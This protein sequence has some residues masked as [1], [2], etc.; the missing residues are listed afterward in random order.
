M[1]FLPRL[2]QTGIG[3]DRLCDHTITVL[4]VGRVTFRSE[5]SRKRGWNG[6]LQENNDIAGFTKCQSNL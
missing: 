4:I 3:A 1:R 6:K 5:K 2:S